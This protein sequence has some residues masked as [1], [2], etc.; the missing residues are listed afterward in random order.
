MITF[1]RPKN[2]DLAGG[3]G[4]TQIESELRKVGA[5]IMPP[6]NGKVRT[7]FVCEVP[8]GFPIGAVCRLVREG[9]D[10]ERGTAMVARLQDG[11][12]FVWPISESPESRKLPRWAAITF[13]GTMPAPPPAKPA[14]KAPAKPPAPKATPV[15]ATPLPTPAAKPAAP[16][17]PAPAKPA[18]AA[19]AP[20]AKPAAKP[21]APAKPPVA[22]KPV[23][24]K[25]AAKAPPP[26]A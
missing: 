1:D 10:A 17:K 15:K 20:A 19:A 14:P 6:Q 3:T 2:F 7:S 12:V 8:A 26:P 5:Q 25:P 16:A 23:A 18:P 11:K 22:V 24:A 9:L 4:E 21:A 13:D